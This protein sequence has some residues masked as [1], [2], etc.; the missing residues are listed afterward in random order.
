MYI[1]LM[2]L[3]F[4][5]L[6]YKYHIIIHISITAFVQPMAQPSQAITKLI[7]GP[8]APRVFPSIF[9]QRATRAEVPL[10]LPVVFPDKRS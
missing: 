1:T 9:S 6:H 4:K 3:Y 10:R 5:N 8:R 2:W 7:D